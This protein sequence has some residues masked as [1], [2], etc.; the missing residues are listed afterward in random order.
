MTF[1]LG[2]HLAI[3]LPRRIVA[4]ELMR[5]EQEW[6]PELAS[7]LPLPVPLPLRLG[8]SSTVFPWPWSVVKWIDGET[9]DLSAFRDGEAEVFAGFLRALHVEAPSAFPSNAV[10]GVPLAERAASFGARVKRLAS[11]SDAMRPQALEIWN[12]AL[13]APQGAQR[14]CMYGDLHARNV[15]G[16]DGAIAGLIDWGD[17][18]AGDRATDLAAVWMLFDSPTA[19]RRVIAAYGEVADGTW[20]RAKGWA[21]LMSAVLVES[22]RLDHARHLRMGRDTQRRV[23]D[24]P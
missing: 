2:R 22:G 1:R 13:D 8:L 15:I 18:C 10:R 19:R 20:Q 3:R 21:V 24:G 5:R 11:T 12:L 14:T 16:C 17:T 23:I 6:L 9:A 7:R 4:V